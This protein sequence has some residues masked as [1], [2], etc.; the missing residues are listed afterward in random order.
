MEC[1][2]VLPK[3]IENEKQ[4]LMAMPNDFTKVFYIDSL[5]RMMHLQCKKL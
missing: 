3:T 4:E 2:D 5:Q 1:V